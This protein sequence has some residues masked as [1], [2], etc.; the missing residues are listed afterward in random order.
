MADDV[1]IR[2]GADASAA[3]DTI[4]D[5]KSALSGVEPTLD[6]LNVTYLAHFAARCRSWSI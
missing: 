4:A 5:L 1:Q 3:V 2:F 6:R